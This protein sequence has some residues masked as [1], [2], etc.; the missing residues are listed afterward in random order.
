[1]PESESCSVTVKAPPWAEC[2]ECGKALIETT[3]LNNRTT[4][5]GVQCEGGHLYVLQWIA[6]RDE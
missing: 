3:A 2:P 4:L 5:G 1:M 6:R